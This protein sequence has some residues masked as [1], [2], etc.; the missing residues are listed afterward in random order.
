M[1]TYDIQKILER[2][3]TTAPYFIGC[4]AS[5]RIPQKAGWF[6]HCMVVNVDPD[7]LQGS[8]WIAIYCPAPERVEYYDP[9][10]NWPPP[11]GPIRHYLQTFEHVRFNDVQL[12]SPYSSTCGKHAIYFLHY[13]CAGHSML[14]I[15]RNLLLQKM[16][17]NCS[18]DRVV[19]S[20]LSNEIFNKI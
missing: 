15:V 9:L 17:I 6:P 4:Y 16:R 7:W 13:R 8:H 1:N 19:C 20:F 11:E 12:Q 5:N 14:E 10:G 3:A 2:N 18:P